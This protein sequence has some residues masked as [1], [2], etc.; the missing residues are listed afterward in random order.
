MAVL[1]AGA[2]AAAPPAPVATAPEPVATTAAPAAALVGPRVPV[3]TDDPTAEE[4]V[5]DAPTREPERPAVTEGQF[6]G[7]LWLRRQSNASEADRSIVHRLSSGFW[8]VNPSEQ[9]VDTTPLLDYG[10]VFDQTSDPPGSLGGTTLVAMHNVTRPPVDLTRVTVDGV[11]Y[12]EPR[13]MLSVYNEKQ[14]ALPPAQRRFQPNTTP[15]DTFE[16]VL[17]N[18]EGTV[19]VLTYEVTGITNSD[20][21]GPAFAALKDPPADPA[22]SRL[23]VYSCWEP[24]SDAS[25]QASFSVLRSRVTRSG[26]VADPG[27]QPPRATP[28]H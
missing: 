14:M 6:M 18:P 13:M 22:E 25:R 12:A 17:N 3:V 5:V 26:S 7:A 27:A 16:V 11:S 10:P 20:P 8:V 9:H 15:G 28:I 19:T 4:P 24:G 1:A 23:V 2:C 21:H